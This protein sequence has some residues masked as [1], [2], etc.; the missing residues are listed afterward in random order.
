MRFTVDTTMGVLDL[1]EVSGT[2]S[3]DL[4]TREAFEVLSREWLRVGWSQKYSYTFTWM[5]RP[6][7]QL[8]ED[9][10]RIQEV[11]CALEP[12]VII[13]TGVAHGGSLVFYACL[14]KALD[15]GRVIGI[16]IHIRPH[17]R[18]AIESHPLSDRITLVEGDSIAV[19]TR[20]HV[21]ALVAPGETVL[22]VLDS[23]HS[24]SHVMSELEAYADLVSK[25][26][27]IVAADGVMRD[28]VSVPRGRPSFGT[29]NPAQA[30]RDFAA[31]NP[32]FAM[33]APPWLF[34]ESDLQQTITYWPEGWLRRL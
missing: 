21:K 20:D 34:N 14:C 24:Y 19:A 3:L 25:G 17:N 29:D 13:E 12:D 31:N 23:N 26:S 9:M 11:I 22:V 27:Y 18:L 1:H 2:R 15:K 30:V 16:D 28:L 5:G 6:I 33:E 10:V 8:P 32:H 7:I 4:Y